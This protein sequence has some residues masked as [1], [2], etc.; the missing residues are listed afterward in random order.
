MPAVTNTE[1][2]N[3]ETKLSSRVSLVRCLTGLLRGGRQQG[4]LINALWSHR[5]QAPE[6]P[7]RSMNAIFGRRLVIRRTNGGVAAWTRPRGKSS[8]N[9]SLLLIVLFRPVCGVGRLHLG[10]H[11]LLSRLAICAALKV[12]RGRCLTEPAAQPCGIVDTPHSGG[13]RHQGRVSRAPRVQR[14]IHGG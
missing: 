8:G 3:Q 5:F 2:A 6:S 10:E 7:P 1:A 14:D 11:L 12:L 9:Q 13:S 4:L